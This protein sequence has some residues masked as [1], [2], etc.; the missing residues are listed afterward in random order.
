MTAN[1]RAK[2][3]M[4]PDHIKKSKDGSKLHRALR[5]TRRRE[6]GAVLNSLEDIFRFDQVMLWAIMKKSKAFIWRILI[7]KKR[8]AGFGEVTS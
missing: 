4:D 1:L 7:G 3:D 8:T 5:L 6:F 2:H